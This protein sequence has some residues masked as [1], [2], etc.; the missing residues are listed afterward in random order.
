MV[1]I[2]NL[3]LLFFLLDLAI[4]GKQMLSKVKEVH[5]LD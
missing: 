4:F 3:R 5:L 2:F 1:Q